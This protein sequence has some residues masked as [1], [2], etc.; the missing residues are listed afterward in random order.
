[1]AKWD[2]EFLGEGL[3]GRPKRLASVAVVV[4]IEMSGIAADQLAESLELSCEVSCDGL[5]QSP[6]RPDER[7][8]SP[9]DAPASQFHV[10]SDGQLGMLSAILGRFASRRAGHHQ[11]GARYDPVLMR[12]DDSSIDAAAAAEV[13]GIHDEHPQ[14]LS[15]IAAN[16]RRCTWGAM[17]IRPTA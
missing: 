9:S 12:L 2:V 5:P 16:L 3:K 17:Q 8:W 4:R 1:V 11:A 10:Q 6:V 15:K 13:V 7:P 14:A